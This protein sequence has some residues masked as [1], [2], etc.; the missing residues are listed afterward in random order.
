M[1]LCFSLDYS[2]NGRT[3]CQAWGAQAPKFLRVRFFK[4]FFKF[5]ITYVTIV[6]SFAKPNSSQ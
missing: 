4:V 5:V 3:H 1:F 2:V 6:G